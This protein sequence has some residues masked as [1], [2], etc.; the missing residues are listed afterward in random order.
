MQGKIAIGIWF[1]FWGLIVLLYNLNIINFNFWAILPY[2]PL[3]I[4]SIGASLIFQNRRNNILI[5]S[6]INIILCL[7]IV[8]IGLTSTNK[9]DITD[10]VSISNSNESTLGSES[11]IATPY[12]NNIKSAQLILNGGGLALRIDSNESNELLEAT[13]DHRGVGFKLARKGDDDHPVLEINNILRNENK[14]SKA[15]VLLNSSPIWDIQINMG[16]AKL[17]ADLRN[18]KISN[19]EVNAGAASMNITLGMPTV[20]DSK[21]N[22]NTAASSF[23][24]NI[25]R[26]AACRL[27]MSTV[28]SSRKL[29]GFEKI[30]DYYQTTNYNTATNKYNISID[31]AA[32]SLKINKY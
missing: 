9:F 7:V 24:I 22:M 23:V 3:L 4:I 6:S 2:W 12:S 27:E 16:A 28:L 31:G 25:P 21:I 32:N 10:T 18:H 13:S 29:D 20:A 14:N 1:V 19:L 11:Q 5:I 8:Y 26:D 15:T 17:N 30:D